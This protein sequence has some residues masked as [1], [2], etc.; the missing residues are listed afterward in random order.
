MNPEKQGVDVHRLRISSEKFSKMPTPDKTLFILLAHISNE[1]CIL[2]RMTTLSTQ[3]LTHDFRDHHHLSQSMFFVRILAAKVLEAWNVLKNNFFSSVLSRKYEGLISEEAQIA[4]KEI[5]KYFS[6]SNILFRVRNDLVFHYPDNLDKEISSFPSHYPLDLL[7]AVQQQNTFYPFAEYI[8][9]NSLIEIT[10][11]KDRTDAT[12]IL[13][14]EAS[15]VAGWFIDF[16]GGYLVAAIET[17]LGGLKELQKE[18]LV[19]DN[20]PPIK[21]L[22]LPWITILEE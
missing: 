7:C 5:K 16:I 17:E 21:S 18:V 22:R 13:S 14:K 1:F 12:D 19:V 4:L 10:S 3:S 9:E 8:I 11:A 2:V 6:S 15:K 20:P